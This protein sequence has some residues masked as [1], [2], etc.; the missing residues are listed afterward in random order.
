MLRSE[1]A[2]EE[3]LLLGAQSL[4]WSLLLRTKDSIIIQEGYPT[5]NGGEE[6]SPNSSQGIHKFDVLEELP[7]SSAR[8]RMTILCRD[9][10]NQKICLYSKGADSKIISLSCDADS[11]V[12]YV[13]DSRMMM[14]DE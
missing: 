12:T 2:D 1:S 5:L 6:S 4:G 3:A 10:W 14:N 8:Q 11:M 7:F 9:T 13:L